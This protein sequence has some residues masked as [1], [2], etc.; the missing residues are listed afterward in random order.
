MVCSWLLS[1]FAHFFLWLWVSCW[2]Q[3]FCQR[4]Q[5]F[6]R[7]H[8]VTHAPSTKCFNMCKLWHAPFVADAFTHWLLL[9]DLVEWS[10]AIDNKLALICRFIFVLALWCPGYRRVSSFVASTRPMMRSFV[11]H[12]LRVNNAWSDAVH[13][14]FWRP[15]MC[16]I[17]Y[18]VHSV[19]A[20]VARS[21]MP[22]H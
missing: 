17:N 15:Q 12:S 7:S 6:Q 18:S 19:F 4:D 9:C 3:A 13:R 1:Q 21:Q 16:A 2:A 22:I 5:L 20:L 8:L 10:E 14:S 11:T